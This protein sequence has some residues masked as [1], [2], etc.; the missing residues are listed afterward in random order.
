MILNNYI[1]VSLHQ[2]KLP[3]KLRV[4]CAI[5]DVQ[6]NFQTHAGTRRSE[7]FSPHNVR[8]GERNGGGGIQ[9]YIDLSHR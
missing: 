7:R 1:C 2:G 3:C 6:R 8:N 4:Y 5:D 9:P